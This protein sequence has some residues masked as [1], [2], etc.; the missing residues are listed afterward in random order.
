MTRAEECSRSC[1]RTFSLRRQSTA[2]HLRY[3]LASTLACVSQGSGSFLHQA[4]TSGMMFMIEV[5]KCMDLRVCYQC[6][7]RQGASSI[8]KAASL[9]LTTTKTRT[10]SRKYTRKQTLSNTLSISSRKKYVLSNMRPRRLHAAVF[11]AY[12]QSTCT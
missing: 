1:G 6:R 9:G 10:P 5:A 12:E 8:A 4:W 7:R 3:A 11:S 2:H